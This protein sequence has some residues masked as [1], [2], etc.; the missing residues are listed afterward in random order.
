MPPVLRNILSVI[1]GIA[2]GSAV[3]MFIV[4]I[5]GKFIPP[6]AGADVTTDEGLKN[7]DSNLAT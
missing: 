7:S 6:P 1:A 2:I 3:N 4:L 5:S